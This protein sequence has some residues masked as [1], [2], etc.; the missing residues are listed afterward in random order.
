MAAAHGIEGRF[1]FLDHRL[2]EFAARVPPRLKMKA[3]D[4]KYLLKRV[5]A[6]LVPDAVVKRSK[7][8]YRAP[9]A[10]SFFDKEKQRARNEY[11]DALLAPDRIADDGV[12]DPRAVA[13]LVEKARHGRIIGTKDNMSLVGV[14]STQ[15]LIDRFLR[16]SPPIPSV[17]CPS[18]I[19]S[20]MDAMA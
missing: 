12:F 5:A 15:I 8:P 20:T 18:L 1:P 11:V 2:A 9:D 10:A 13:A 14:L 16:E 3:L 17:E 6:P 4:E 19:A 7:Q